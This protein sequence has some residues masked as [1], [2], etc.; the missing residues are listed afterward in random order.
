M[1]GKKFTTEH[2]RKLRISTFEYAKKVSNIICPR[3]GHNEKKILDK[4]EQ[5]L[6]YK[7][8]R[9]YKVCGYFVDGYIPELKLV[10]EID[11]IPKIREK[12][13]E[14][15]DIIENELNCKFIRINDFD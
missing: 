12:D 2:K 6:K 9:Q 4:L 11:E 3:I 13:I 7:I 10:I 15:Q 8:L 1:K 14:R 5:E